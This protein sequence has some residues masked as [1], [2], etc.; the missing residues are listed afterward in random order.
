DD[1]SFGLGYTYNQT[2][3]KNSIAPYTVGRERDSHTFDA[4]VEFTHWEKLTGTASAGLTVNQIQGG[5]PPLAQVA[6]SLS[7]T[8]GS[9]NPALQYAYSENLIFTLNGT[10]NFT[11]GATGQNIENTGAGLGFNY[12]YGKINVTATLINFNYSQ[13]LQTPRDDQAKSSG[14]TITW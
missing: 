1:L 14:V 13:Y 9:S 6:S 11:V 12:T 7:T 5:N 4:N 10:R 8:T 2:D 3:Q